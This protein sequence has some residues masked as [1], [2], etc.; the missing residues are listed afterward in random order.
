[1]TGEDESARRQ[2][3][4]LGDFFVVEP[5]GA[6][7]DWRPLTDL[8]DGSGLGER[9]EATG[10]ALEQIVGGDVEPRVAA[11]TASLGLFARLLSPALGATLLDVPGPA[12]AGLQWR[13]APTGPLPL[14][15][16]AWSDEAL[17]ATLADVVEPLAARLETQHG[18]ARA[19]VRGNAAS[20]VMGSL[21][22]AVTARRDLAGAA[23]R[24]AAELFATAFLAGTALPGAPFVRRSCCL[25]YRLPGGGYCGD[26][27]LAPAHRDRVAADKQ[28]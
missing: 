5:S 13:H 15:A 17:T 9:T 7:G 22:M 18:L 20:A 1:M 28:G 14:R 4:A 26:C 25:Y 27:V 8:T 11:S 23:D 10:R 16:T 24:V 2:V 21:R 6:P 12:P 3:A 19:V